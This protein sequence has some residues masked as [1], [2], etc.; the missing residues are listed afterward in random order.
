LARKKKI[1]KRGGG[2]TGP[3]LQAAL[4]TDLGYNR[5]NIESEEIWK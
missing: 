4:T 2:P 5:M 3:K 1:K